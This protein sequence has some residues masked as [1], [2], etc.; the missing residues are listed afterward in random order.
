MLKAHYSYSFDNLS[1]SSLLEMKHLL[2]Q[3]GILLTI[4]LM[5]EK[6]VQQPHSHK[7]NVCI[8]GGA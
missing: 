2:M 8:D 6:H 3:P 4:W 1:R 7:A 5:N